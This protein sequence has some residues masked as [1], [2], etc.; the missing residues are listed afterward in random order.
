MLQIFTPTVKETQQNAFFHELMGAAVSF[1]HTIVQQFT[2][3][4]FLP[5]ILHPSRQ[6]N[7]I[8]DN[9]VGTNRFRET[10]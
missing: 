8:G 10:G 2:I 9:A 7:T 5:D 6:Q 3:P 4:L 1:T